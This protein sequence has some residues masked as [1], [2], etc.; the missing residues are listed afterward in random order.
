VG[1]ILF[2]DQIEKSVP[3]KKGRRHV[4]RVIR[5][6]LYHQP[7][8][9][10]TDLAAAIEHLNR[11]ARRRGVVF[12]VSD[13][14]DSGYERGLQVARRRHDLIPIVITDP[15]EMEMPAVGLVELLDAETGELVLVD[16]SS[17][18]FREGFAA[19]A[20]RRSEQREQMLRRLDVESIQLTTGE[21]FVEPLM[22]HFRKKH[23]RR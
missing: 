17:R 18:G 22:R 6:L 12:L 16:T 8:G 10:G 9:R 13:F 5:D 19:D 7:A 14:Q 11:V 3:A 20:R 4:L 15:R 21:P 23:A 1:S 2:T